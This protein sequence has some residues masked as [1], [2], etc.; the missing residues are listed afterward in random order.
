MGATP[1][2]AANLAS[3]P[4]RSGLSPTMQELAGYFRSDSGKIAEHRRVGVEDFLERGISGDDFCREGLVARAFNVSRHTYSGS[5]IWP[6][7]RVRCRA[8]I[9]AEVPSP[10]PPIAGHL[11]HPKLSGHCRDGPA[12]AE[13]LRRTRLS[14]A[15]CIS[16]GTRF[17]R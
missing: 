11:V 14:S 10:G 2:R 5:A 4:R 9:I 3:F 8:V 15:A 7:G 1:T 6:E 17:S 13:R 16:T 12:T